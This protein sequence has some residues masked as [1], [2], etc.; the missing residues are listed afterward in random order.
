M[1]SFFLPAGLLL[2]FA[3]AWI[4]PEVGTF[5]NEIGLVPWLMV[6]IFVINGYQIKLSEIPREFNFLYALLATAVISL[7]IAPFIGAQAAQLFGLSTAATLG[8]I[9]KSTV[10]ATLST[11]IVMTQIAGGHALWALVMTVVLN[12]LGVFTIPFMLSLNVSAIGEIT[13]D[14]FPL[15]QTLMLFVLV[16]LLAGFFAKRILSISAD[17]LVLQYLPSSCVI[18]T[19]WIML[20]ASAAVFKSLDLFLLI[21]IGVAAISVHFLLMIICWAAARGMKLER[22]ALIA[23]IFTGSQKTLPVAV[24][25]LSALNQPIG[26]AVLVCICFHFLQLFADSLIIGRMVQAKNSG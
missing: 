2:A 17:H 8:L 7:L 16:P 10:P 26:I 22:G 19:V 15:L 18:L 4:L 6:I 12:I 1:K 13:V 3:L 21:Q 24:G 9:V 11:C 14:P 23:M 20:S 25:V 5:L